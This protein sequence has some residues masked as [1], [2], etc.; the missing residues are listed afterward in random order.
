MKPPQRAFCLID[1]QRRQLQRTARGRSARARPALTLRDSRYYRDRV[2]IIVPPV[3]PS[4]WNPIRQ[5]AL[6]G[7]RDPLRSAPVAASFTSPFPIAPKSAD[8]RN[9]SA[10][11]N[12]IER[13]KS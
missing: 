10:R 1:P 2:V 4:L 13:M 11:K 12:S 5:F 9:R 3:R 8:Q 7:I 6:S